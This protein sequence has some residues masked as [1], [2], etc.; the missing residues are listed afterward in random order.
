MHC[1][2]CDALME[3]HEP[4][5]IW[6]RWFE[7]PECWLAFHLESWELVLGRLPSPYIMR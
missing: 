4:D 1:P 2:R 5:K 7:C 6:M 3:W